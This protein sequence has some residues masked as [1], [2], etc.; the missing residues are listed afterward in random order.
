MRVN[1]LCQS[2]RLHGPHGRNHPDSMVLWSVTAGRMFG[3]S[4][5]N[6][7]SAK[8]AKAALLAVPLSF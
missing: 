1:E 2:R 3:N 6:P 8:P 5:E 4:P 7:A